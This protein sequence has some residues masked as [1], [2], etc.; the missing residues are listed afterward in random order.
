MKS[1]LVCPVSTRNC[2]SQSHIIQRCSLS[3]CSSCCDSLS[4]SVPM[5]PAGVE[6]ISTQPGEEK[7]CWDLAP[8]SCWWN[9]LTSRPLRIISPWKPC[10]AQLQGE[11][12]TQTTVGTRPLAAVPCAGPDF[13]LT[14]AKP[15]PI[16][17]SRLSSSVPSLNS[18]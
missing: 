4:I 5:T 6:D 16:H 12:F 8:S 15:I 18:H 11:P 7:S 2:S 3:V 17:P 13:L 9:I 10:T 1:K 14:S